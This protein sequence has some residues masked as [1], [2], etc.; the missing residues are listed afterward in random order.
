MQNTEH[1]FF[2]VGYKVGRACALKQVNAMRNHRHHYAEMLDQEDRSEWSYCDHLYRQGYAEGI[3][4][5]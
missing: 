4:S 1:A 2:E 3:A 5:K